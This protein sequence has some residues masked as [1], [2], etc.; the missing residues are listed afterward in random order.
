M[1]IWIHTIYVCI[2][3]YVWKTKERLCKRLQQKR[4]FRVITRFCLEFYCEG[5]P[6]VSSK[7]T[8]NIIIE[9]RIKNISWKKVKFIYT[10]LNPYRINMR[11][12]EGY[13]E[14][15]HD[16]N[17]PSLIFSS[18]YWFVQYWQCILHIVYDQYRFIQEDLHGIDIT[19]FHWLSG[20]HQPFGTL[21]LMVQRD[22]Y[23]LLTLRL[24]W[25]KFQKLFQPQ[26]TCCLI[27]D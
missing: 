13:F 26:F 1:L 25:S 10:Y 7:E 20:C 9:T 6:L 8:V 22:Q 4:I 27:G 19:E 17:C 16:A 2:Y 21:F 3:V 23:G 15:I 12:K 18:Y 5:E 24:S 11:N 14:K